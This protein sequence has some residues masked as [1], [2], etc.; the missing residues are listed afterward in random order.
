MIQV[1]LYNVSLLAGITLVGVGCGLHFGLG[2]GLASAGVLTVAA[3]VYGVERQPRLR[4]KLDRLEQGD[5]R[6]AASSPGRILLDYLRSRMGAV[7]L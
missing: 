3:A 1:V 5:G 4:K 2:I 6:V 7:R